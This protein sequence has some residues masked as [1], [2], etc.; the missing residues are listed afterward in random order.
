MRPEELRTLPA[1]RVL[2]LDGGLGSM[3]IA[4]GLEA[5]RAPDCWNLERPDRV[6]AVH[7]A[8]ADAGADIVH[9]NTFGAN[10]ARLAVAGLAGRCVEVN[11][12]AT[13][14]ARR[15]AGGRAL[16]AGDIGPSGHAL[17]PVGTARL[18]ELRE[19]FRLQAGALAGAGVDLL[20]IET[21][22]DV[23][24]AL[25]A[26]EA[27]AE[28]GLAVIASMTFEARRRGAFTVMG[29][30]LVESLRR[31][32]AAGAAAV[33]LNCSVTA[34]VMLAMVRE[35][36]PA[37]GVPLAAQANAG[38]PEMREGEIAYRA[39]PDEFARQAVAMVESGA[40]LIGGCCGT[41]PEFIARIAAALAAA[42]LR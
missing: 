26:V 2:L 11:V 15:A 37:L 21:M 39:D 20:S 25:A 32:A 19:G 4:A 24:E 10:P 8:Y 12:A 23:R 34:E 31:L 40:R 18:D 1:D 17:P 33:G 30:P 42:G 14:I 5:G 36:A 35:A 29:D 22:T 38:Q 6:E 13:A 28:T 7:L 27:A 3:L 16:V 9:T 41:T